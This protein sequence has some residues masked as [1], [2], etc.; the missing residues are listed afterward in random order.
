[1]SR[2]K[3]KIKKR[4]PVCVIYWHDAAFSF[5]KKLPKQT[6]PLQVTAGFIVKATNT[7]VNIATNVNYYPRTRGV[8][9]V[10][11]LVIPKK[12]IIKFRKIGFLN[13]KR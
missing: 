11:G 7:Y 4:N 12:A 8:W 3:A 2:I 9:P 6:V 5:Y 13:A 10:D 1:M